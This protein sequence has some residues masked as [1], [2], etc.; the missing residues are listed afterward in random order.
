MQDLRVI[1]PISWQS[2]LREPL[3]SALKQKGYKWSKGNSLDTCSEKLMQMAYVAI[4]VHKPICKFASHLAKAKD[5]VSEV[6][7]NYIVKNYSVNEILDTIKYLEKLSKE[8]SENQLISFL[9]SHEHYLKL[10][11]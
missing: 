11:I 8:L 6:G 5:I 2:A 10:L 4:Y 9:Q 3:F 1:V 7:L